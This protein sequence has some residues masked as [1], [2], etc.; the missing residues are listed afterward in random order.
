MTIYINTSIT[1]PGAANFKFNNGTIA[2]ATVL[3]IDNIDS[4]ASNI[5]SFLQTIDDST[6]AIK[7]T[8]KVTGL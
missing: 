4:N 3:Y 8:I 6:S 1:D 7:G 2:S 5:T